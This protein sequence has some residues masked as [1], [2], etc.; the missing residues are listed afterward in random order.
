MTFSWVV[1]Y[2]VGFDVG[3]SSKITLR[4]ADAVMSMLFERFDALEDAF[5]ATETNA[6]RRA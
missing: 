3:P 4:F 2:V 6:V 1:E 5:F